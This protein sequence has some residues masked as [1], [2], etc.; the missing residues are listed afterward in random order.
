MS[1]IEAQS[2]RKA[3]T[4]QLSFED[5]FHVS[6][7]PQTIHGSPDMRFF[8]V[9]PKDPIKDPFMASL[10]EYT[11]FTQGNYGLR[12]TTDMDYQA[13]IDFVNDVRVARHPAG[14]Q[15]RLERAVQEEERKWGPRPFKPE[16]MGKLKDESKNGIHIYKNGATFDLDLPEGLLK[17]QDIEKTLND[18]AQ[19]LDGGRIEIRLPFYTLSFEPKG[20]GLSAPNNLWHANSIIG[21]NDFSC[22]AKD[23]VEY[24]LSKSDLPEDVKTKAAQIVNEALSQREEENKS[25]LHIEDMGEYE[26][27]RTLR[28]IEFTTRTNMAG[29]TWQG[30]SFRRKDS[31]LAIGRTIKNGNGT[32]LIL[33]LNTDLFTHGNYS[34]IRVSYE[35]DD[36]SYLDL[37]DVA[38]ILNA[39]K[40][41]KQK[42]VRLILNSGAIKG[43]YIN[44]FD[45]KGPQIPESLDPQIGFEYTSVG[46][47]AETAIVE[48][49]DGNI[50]TYTIGKENMVSASLTLSNRFESKKS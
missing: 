11:E 18:R 39:D 32:A 40:Y 28:D 4:E 5:R 42:R 3:R 10:H 2:Q 23:D 16:T 1:T 26:T 21:I 15:T 37:V 48:S 31:K 36:G 41:R 49:Q 17:I 33:D 47:V 44:V 13:F 7:P 46:F 50:N 43:N 14:L 34:K 6:A 30:E 38:K 45:V 12:L 29:E 22:D 20:F 35:L 19:Q 8:E 24:F 9:F 27:L 25:I